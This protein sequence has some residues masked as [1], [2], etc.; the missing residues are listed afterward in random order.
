MRTK[1][2]SILTLL[3]VL[4]V[5]ITFAQERT[6]T[7]TVVD[8]DG[9]PLPGVTVMIQGTNT[10]TQTDFDGNYSIDATQGDIL[11]FSFVGMETAEYAVTN[12][13]TI[14]VTLSTDS[15]QLDE[16]VVTA[17][18]IERE[19]KSLGYATQSVDGS[20]VSDVPTQNFV[21]SLSGKVAGLDI[22]SSG[23]MG[24]SSNVVIRGNSS[25]TGNNQA[26]FVIDGTPISNA[27]NNRSGQASG[28]GGYD[29][30]NAAS[31]IN[32]NDIAS[33]N[34]LKGAAATALYGARAANGVIIIETKKGS[35]GKGIGVSVNSTLMTSHVN[36]NTL[37]EYQDQ[38]GAGYGR[39]YGPDGDAYF[40][41]Y[42][43][44]GDGNLDPVT[45]FTE[46]ASF[47]GIFDGAPIYQWNSIYPQLEGTEYDFYQQATPWEA[48]ANNPNAIWETGY[49]MINSVALDG[50]TDRS[51]F[52]LSATNFNQQGNLPNSQIKRNTL[53]FSASHDF[54]DK[55]SAQTNVTYTKTDGKGRYGTG[56]SSLNIMQQFRQWWQ[57]NVDLYDQRA[58][59]F[60]TGENIT[61][62]PNGPDDLSPIYSDN[63]Y[64]TLY[65][66]YQTDTRNR[67]F[68][69]INLNYEINDVFSV[70][71]RFTFDT[72]DELQEQRINVGSADIPEYSRYNNRAAE[73]NYDLILNFNKDVTEDLNLDGN[74]GFNLRRN[75]RSYILASTNGGLNAP[76]FYALSNSSAPIN[77]PTEYESIRMLDGI[78]AR[79]GLGYLDTYFLEGTIRRDRSSTLPI[80]NNTFYYPSI[81]TS[82]ILSNVIEAN[83]LS[84]AKLRANYAEVGSDTNPYRVFNTYAISAPFGTA[85][86]ASNNSQL[87]NLNLKPERMKA[88]EVGLEANFADRRIAFDVS[89]Y[90]SQ[91][92]NQI[93]P[94]PVSTATGFATKLLNAGTVEN[95]GIEVSLTLNPIRTEDFDWTI[96]ANW[97]KNKSEVLELDEGIDNLQLASFQGGVSINAAPGEPYGAIRGSAYV[98]DDNGNRVITDGGYYERTPNANYI[99]GNIQPDWTGG[100][101]NT[102]TYK[103]LTFSF[104]IDVQKGGD[105]FS[106]DTWYG[107]ATGLYAT[108][109][110]TN[111]LGNP[112]RNPL[113]DPELEP[114]DPGYIAEENQGGVILD[115]VQGD[116]SYNDDGTYEV[117]NTSEN[118]V[119]ARTDYFGNPYGYGRDANEGHVYDAS[120]VKL[121]EVSLA[122]NFGPK[123]IDATPFTSASL[124]LIGRNLWIIHKNIPYSDPEAG[125]SSGNA[126]GYQSGA[127]PAV[128]EIGASLRFNF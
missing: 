42:D 74:L 41:Q 12:V 84:F 47:G 28:R 43:V 127:Y 63:P 22:S 59:Y 120:F 105:I 49:T 112:I 58:A 17:L 24:G 33:I 20:E 30:G 106:L 111:E 118:T 94:V 101:S 110:G 1:F 68:G 100:V 87:A 96:N 88:Y 34:V 103:N 23:T 99:I 13:D 10:G 81:S 91:T 45:P 119:R 40:N 83:W 95:K 121:R 104:L 36:D 117:T 54:T 3:L 90:N 62:N 14:D 39:F 70:L 67:Y 82:V 86:Y 108:S 107:R 31:D 102:L 128:R 75:E 76:G 61:W 55:F 9:L 2:S 11:V 125:L 52:R 98:Y 97:A 78:Y 64:W 92:E 122:Y 50:G 53:K 66:N 32:P 56:Y 35:K 18:G 80:E 69:N 60:A 4:A 89:Y 73:Y 38:Y 19:K 115:G 126:Q 5:Q 123:I 48:G 21:N 124:S 8:E 7:G 93:T 25:L 77:P 114:G 15:A 113:Y 57:T 109:V 79:A 46:D 29:Y 6:I 16:V 65:E 85:G 26:L 51:S 116:V 71:G 72:Y 44:D 37:P 27:N